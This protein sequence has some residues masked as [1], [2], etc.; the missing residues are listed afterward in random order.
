MKQKVCVVIG[1][2]MAMM[3][4]AAPK[5]TVV[6]E[7]PAPKTETAPQPEVPAPTE[8]APQEDDGLRMPDMLAMP[9]EGDFRSTNPSAPKTTN[10]SGAVIS[11]PPTDPPSRVKPKAE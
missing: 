2:A 11:R 8:T 9:Q 7:A 1:M 3:S 5:A 10:Q 4:C 6:A